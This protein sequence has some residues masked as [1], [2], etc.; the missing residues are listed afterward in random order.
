MA[1][2]SRKRLKSSMR[3]WAFKTSTRSETAA[4]GA[5]APEAAFAVRSSMAAVRAAR[6]ASATS[7]SRAAGSPAVSAP[8][9]YS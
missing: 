9:A 7:R 4:S 5:F 1:V 3:L 8:L 6:R 2:A